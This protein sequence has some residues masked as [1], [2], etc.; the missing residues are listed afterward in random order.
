VVVVLDPS[1]PPSEE[2]SLDPEL[3]PVVSTELDAQVL[4]IPIYP[5]AGQS[6]GVSAGQSVLAN[7]IQ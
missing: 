3:P 4:D 6:V 5:G 1:V 2:P 7:E